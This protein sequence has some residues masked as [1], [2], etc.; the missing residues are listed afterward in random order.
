VLTENSVRSQNAEVP[1]I[2]EIMGP[3]TMSSLFV[4]LFALI[5]SSFR[6]RVALQAEILA[7]RHQLAVLQKSAASLARSPLRPLPNGSASDLRTRKDRCW[8]LWS[9]NS[10]HPLLMAAYTWGR[11]KNF[12]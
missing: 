8:R 3:T 11:E 2:R 12:T 7:L 4:G 1:I 9:S 10:P 5:A 6:T